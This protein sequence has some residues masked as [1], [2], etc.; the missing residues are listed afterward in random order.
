MGGGGRLP[1]QAAEGLE[2]RRGGRRVVDGPPPITELGDEQIIPIHLDIEDDFGFSIL[3]IGYEIIRPSFIET[4]PIISVYSVSNLVPD[5]PKQTVFLD[6]DLSEIMLMPE[7]EIH[8]HF[9]LYDN[10]LVSGPKKS[11]SGNFVARLPSL[12][13]LFFGIEKKEDILMEDLSMN[14]EDVKQIQ[15]QILLLT[16]KD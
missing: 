11:L 6:W 12:E 10:D 7:D 8:Y 2:G 15:E 16:K 5:K 9:E 1:A 13:D 4:D 14:L 3:Q